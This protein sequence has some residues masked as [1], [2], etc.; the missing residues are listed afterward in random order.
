MACLCLETYYRYLPV[1]EIAAGRGR[2]IGRR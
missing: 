1:L 2:G